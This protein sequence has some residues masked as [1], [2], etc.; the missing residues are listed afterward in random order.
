[1][2]KCTDKIVFIFI[3]YA[4]LKT[5][6]C[7]ASVISVAFDSSYLLASGSNDNTVK[8]WDK[9]SGNQLRSLTGHINQVQAV[10]FDS[11]NML[12]SGSRDNTIKLWDKNSGG[13]LRTLTGHGYIVRSVAFDFTHLLASGSWDNTIKI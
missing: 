6:N 8:I 3:D 9:N 5:L 13:L 7:G 4:L 12:A 1:M 11:N 10:A 2:K